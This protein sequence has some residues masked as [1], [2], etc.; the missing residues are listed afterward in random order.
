MWKYEQRS[1]LWRTYDLRGVM[2]APSWIV[3]TAI[4]Y[5]GKEVL[6]KYEYE[7]HGHWRTDMNLLFCQ[8]AK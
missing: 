8:V 1:K 4:A 7:V 6:G 5:S 2:E 3:N